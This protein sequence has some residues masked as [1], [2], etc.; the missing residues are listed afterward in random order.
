MTSGCGAHLRFHGLE[1]AMGLHPVLWPVHHTTS[2]TCRYLPSFYT[3]TKLYCL[4]TEAHKCEQLTQGC[5]PTVRRPGLELMT[6]ESQV[7]HHIA[8]LLIAVA[9][10]WIKKTKRC[11][12]PDV[13]R[14]WNKVYTWC[15]TITIARQSC[16]FTWITTQCSYII[17]GMAT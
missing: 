4:V 1:L 5:Y 16:Y 12:S 15:I 8:R 9:V 3:G 14:Q 6:T 2:T 17:V 11:G 10:K 7:K 13:R